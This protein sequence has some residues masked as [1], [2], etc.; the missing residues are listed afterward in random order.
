M[1]TNEIKKGTRFRLRNGWEATMEDNRKGNIR[2]ATVEGVCTEMGS[3]YAHDIVSV[4]IGEAWQPVT[5][6]DKQAKCRALNHA[7]FGD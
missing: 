7:L 3:V 2:M 1:T 6:T 5:K 4:L